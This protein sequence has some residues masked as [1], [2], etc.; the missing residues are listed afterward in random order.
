MSDSN[1]FIYDPEGIDL[2]L[3]KD[4]KEI[5]R[6]RIKEYVEKDQVQHTHQ[7]P[8]PWTVACDIAISMRHS[9]RT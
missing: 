9:E 8:R 7:M 5:R 6:G 2:D 3:V 1:G 4:I